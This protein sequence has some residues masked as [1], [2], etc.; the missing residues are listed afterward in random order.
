MHQKNEI[1]TIAG[2]PGCD[3]R[4]FT[5]NKSKPYL[6]VENWLIASLKL[7]VITVMY[8]C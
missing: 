6:A 8:S 2:Y 7:R 4:M 1:T 3:K 5:N